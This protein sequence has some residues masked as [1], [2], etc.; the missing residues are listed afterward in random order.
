MSRSLS[1]VSS[2]LLDESVDEQDD[3]AGE[4]ADD[5]LVSGESTNGAGGDDTSSGELVDVVAQEFDRADPK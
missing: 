5:V 1:E 4:N 3:E 2:R